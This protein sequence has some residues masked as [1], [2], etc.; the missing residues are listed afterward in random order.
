MAVSGSVFH[1][2]QGHCVPAGVLDS[3]AQVGVMLPII[4]KDYEKATP[5]RLR[6]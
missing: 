2:T 1:S 4:A 3:T 6:L 5:D